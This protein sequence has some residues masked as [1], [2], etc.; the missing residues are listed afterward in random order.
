[1]HLHNHKNKK[2]NKKHL[3]VKILHVTTEYYKNIR[4]STYSNLTLEC[5]KIILTN[6]Y[7]KTKCICLY[8]MYKLNVEIWLLI[9]IVIYC[10]INFY[11]QS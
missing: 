8:K 9:D 3:F 1:M 2:I 7:T 11:F 10:N 5:F 6:D 4:L